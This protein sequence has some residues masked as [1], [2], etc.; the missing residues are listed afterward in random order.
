MSA[1]LILLVILGIFLIV[2]LHLVLARIV[3]DID[4]LPVSPSEDTRATESLL[5]KFRIC[6]LQGHDHVAEPNG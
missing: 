6:R 5:S 3:S 4:K 2:A 1:L